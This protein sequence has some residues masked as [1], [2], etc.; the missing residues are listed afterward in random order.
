MPLTTQSPTALRPA[1]RAPPLYSAHGV[2]GLGLVV[3]QHQGDERADY[4]QH[5]Q[6]A[7]ETPP[8]FALPHLSRQRIE[9]IIMHG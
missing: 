8:R 2:S 7:Q 4:W 6:A 9:P 5:G 1:A 3:I